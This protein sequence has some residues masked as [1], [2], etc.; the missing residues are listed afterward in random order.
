MEMAELR[1]RRESR[2][3]PRANTYWFMKFPNSLT[4]EIT[5]I[6]PILQL[7]TQNHL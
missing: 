2:L 1:K 3:A 5:I 6:I 7:R 4:T